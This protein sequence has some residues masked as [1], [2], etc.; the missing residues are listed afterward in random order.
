MY[1]R[2]FLFAAFA[3]SFICIAADR[4][5]ATSS[6]A[7]PELLFQK[8]RQWSLPYKPLD[9]VQSADGNMVF[10]LTENNRVLIYSSEGILKGTIPVDAGVS[11]IGTDIRGENILLMDD[12]NNTFTSVSFDIIR[13]IDITG[14]PYKGADNAPVIVAV[15]TNYQ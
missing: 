13:E 7:S 1:F 14:S 3:L 9:M 5:W 8:T 2:N 15:F 6:P 10:F 11:K 4:V 12:K